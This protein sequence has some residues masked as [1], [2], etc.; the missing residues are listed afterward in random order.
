MLVLRIAD[1]R[2]SQTQRGRKG[3]RTIREIRP[4]LMLMFLCLNSTDSV[5]SRSNVFSIKADCRTVTEPASCS[6]GRLNVKKRKMYQPYCY[7][8]LIRYPSRLNKN[9]RTSNSR[10][11]V[12]I[13]SKKNACDNYVNIPESV[14]I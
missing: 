7:T 3:K 14:P 11:V 2:I 9:H 10:H 8:S 4:L 5:Y 6:E 1:R 13:A 12:R